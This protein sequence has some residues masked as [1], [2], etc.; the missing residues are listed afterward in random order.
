MHGGWLPYE[1]PFDFKIILQIKDNTFQGFGFVK[2][3]LMA[4][5]QL[6]TKDSKTL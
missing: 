1:V 5:K 3:T 6:T 4:Y 2:I